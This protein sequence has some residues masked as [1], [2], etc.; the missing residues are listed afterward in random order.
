MS[1]RTAWW[2]ENPHIVIGDYNLWVIKISL[3]PDQCGSVCWASSRKVKGHRF[4][5]W[6][7]HMPGF[8]DQSSVEACAGVTNLFLSHIDVSVPLFLPSFPLDR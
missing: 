2:E 4:N 5:S 3:G 7:G 1:L 8:W 6:S